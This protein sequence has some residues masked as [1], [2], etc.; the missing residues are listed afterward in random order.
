MGQGTINVTTGGV[1]S[2]HVCQYVSQGFPSGMCLEACIHRAVIAL[3]TSHPLHTHL[4]H[5]HP[6]TFHPT[7]AHTHTH[8]HTHTHPSPFCLKAYLFATC[9]DCHLRI[10][11]D[12]VA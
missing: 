10:C 3:Q 12:C 9:S 7:H 2:F 4:L 8:T 11:A 6:P 1:I 5:P